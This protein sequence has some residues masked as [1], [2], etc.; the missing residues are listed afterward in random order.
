MLPAKELLLATLE[1]LAEG[2]GKLE[3]FQWFLTSLLP[4]FPPIP[5]SQL[6]DPDRQDTVDE[7]VQSFGPEVAVK[8]TLRILKNLKQFHLAE[9]LEINY[10]QVTPFFK[11]LLTSPGA[12]GDQ[13]TYDDIE[14]GA[15]EEYD[16]MCY[17]DLI[18]RST[19]AHIS[20][21]EGEHEEYEIC[22]VID[23][24][25]TSAPPHITIP[26]RGAE[27]LYPDIKPKLKGMLKRSLSL[28]DLQVRT[29]SS[30]HR[31]SDDQGEYINMSSL[32]PTMPTVPDLLLAT[33]E[34]LNAEE[35]K[36]FLSHLAHCLLSIFP[37]IPWSQLENADTKV[38]VDKM[39]QCYSLEYAVKITVVIL[40]MMKWFDLADKL[41]N[42][43]RLGRRRE[44]SKTACH[45]SSLSKGK[46]KE[47][48]LFVSSPSAKKEE[49]EKAIA[50]HSNRDVMGPTKLPV[51]DL[52]RAT[53]MELSK[54]VR[55]RFKFFLTSSLLPG[56]P[57]IPASQLRY[58]NIEVT[59]DKMVQI[60]GPEG[61]VEI[62][63]KILRE[64]NQHNLADELKRE[65]GRNSPLFLKP[66]YSS[67]ALSSLPSRPSTR[68]RSKE[69]ESEERIEVNPSQSLTDTK[70]QLLSNVFGKV[71]Q[72]MCMTDPLQAFPDNLETEIYDESRGA[73][74]F[75]C[76]CAG[77]FPSGVTGLGFGMEGEGEVLY[78]TVPW[79]RRLLAQR[80]KRPAGPLFKFTCLKGSVCQLH[81]PHCELHSKGGCDFLSVAHVMDD[82]LEF[83]RDVQITDKH[84]ILNITG[85]SAYGVVKEDD[86]PTV[87]IRALVLLFYKP[88]VVPKKRSIL[89][90]L[91]L[92]RNVMIRE[93]QEEWKRR[94]GDEEIYIETNAHCQLIPKQEYTLSTD[95]VDEH[96]IR[97]KDAAF[98]DF[99]SYENY[100]PTF[101]L[102]LQTVV[103][104]VDLLLKE[105]GGA[106][107]VWDRLV[108]LPVTVSPTE[109]ISTASGPLSVA[110]PA[111]PPTLS[112]ENFITKQRVKLEEHMGE[113][114]PILLKLQGCKVLNDMEREKIDNIS[115]R[116]QRNK[117]LLEM[118][119]R[120]GPRAQEQLYQAIKKG[121]P[122]LVEY[123]EEETS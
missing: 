96:Q 58:A 19:Q 100:I 69:E 33:L 93:V 38:T 81:L 119:M 32:S 90:V 45:T 56:F 66:K 30:S 10:G 39:V 85:F 75:K 107:S 59:V 1:E 117:A 68:E 71:G 28:D 103:E 40:K 16:V 36:R 63:L 86:S 37:P 5:E 3:R 13:E 99:E 113:L 24:T 114:Q 106:E 44:Q 60:F 18:S 116:V 98:V 8:I 43:Y 87:P 108:W 120:K 67:V 15:G 65:H 115:S 76:P 54:Q 57:P 48:D 95:L 27:G 14:E 7:M 62:T 118:V 6:D 111:D 35:F 123:L 9:K 53:L 47:E 64:M 104:Q 52:L 23:I 80:G 83:I 25:S 2:G 101:Q 74:R 112:G 55:R 34:M 46:E 77:L 122:Y 41:R 78:W 4:I 12:S 82:S 94:N 79:D 84:V 50:I 110:P 92:P 17:D 89:N 51:A 88:P 31:V 49:Q 72:A 97:P 20:V 11:Y 42:N 70:E 73:Y 26:E 121:D 61:A 22:D 91:L 21:P 102:F 105:N 29:P 109:V